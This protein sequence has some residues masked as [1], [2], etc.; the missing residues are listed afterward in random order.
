MAALA[1]LPSLARH[2]PDSLVVLD[3]GCR[4]GF[5]PQWDALD[6]Q[7]ELYGFDADAE[8]VE[9]LVARYAD[10]P[11]AHFI[12]ATLGAAP[13]NAVLFRT[14]ERGCSSV[15]KPASDRV[16]HLRPWDGSAIESTLPVQTVTLDSWARERGVPRVDAIKL[17]T[18][19]SELEIL[20]GATEV[21]RDVR[22]IE[23]EV[24]FNEISEGAPLFGEVDGFLRRSGF[25]LW[26]LRD[27]VSYGLADAL[28]PPRTTEHFWYESRAESVEMPGGQ[29]VWCNAHFA[30]RDMYE[31]GHGPGWISR[32]RDAC[33]TQV[34]GFHDL[35][36]RSLKRMLDEQCPSSLRSEAREL[37][38]ATPPSPSSTGTP[39]RFRR[40]L[41]RVSR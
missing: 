25:A 1:D 32:L 34:N 29:L 12:A 17:D 8:E 28:D 38:E 6:S 19:G 20:R 37:L 36:I 27:L 35:A 14:R 31:P 11:E 24:A 5:G 10:R 16:D 18:Q 4:W 40:A 9:R 39:N 30:R 41:R 3:A 23:V 22:Y 7:V 15:F 26:R 2:L 21:L 33:L 13:G